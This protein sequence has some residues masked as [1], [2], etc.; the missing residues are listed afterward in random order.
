MI[1]HLTVGREPRLRLI[2]LVFAEAE[3]NALA[4][5]RCEGLKAVQSELEQK[6]KILQ[7]KLKKAEKKSKKS[8]K[9][10]KKEKKHEKKSRHDKDKSDE[11]V[12]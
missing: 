6:W 2:M 10:H 8:K 4:N 11:K 1:P 12:R 3:I 7:S 9:K 5:T